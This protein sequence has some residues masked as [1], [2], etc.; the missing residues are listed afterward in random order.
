M[1]Q[2]RSCQVKEINTDLLV[3]FSDWRQVEKREDHS[4]SGNWGKP[5]KK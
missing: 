1:T 5:H 4:Q 3:H 2:S